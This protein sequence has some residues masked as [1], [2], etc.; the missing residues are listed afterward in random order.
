MKRN[1]ILLLT[2]SINH[3]YSIDVGILKEANLSQIK[4]NLSGEDGVSYFLRD[5]QDL[6][7]WDLVYE[8]PIQNQNEITLSADQS[9]NFF[10]LESKFERR[11]RL[12]IQNYKK[13]LINGGPKILN[14]NNNEVQSTITIEEN[15]I[16]N[17]MVITAN[18]IP[19]YLSLIHI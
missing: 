19:N 1:L 9:R 3:L 2:L 7:E 15:R 8:E 4:I 10:T 14:L 6:K 17:E 12:F 16:N 13:Q 11:A 5:S 18:G